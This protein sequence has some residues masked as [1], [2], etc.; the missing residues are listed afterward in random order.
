MKRFLVLTALLALL[1]CGER[2]VLPHPTALS[3][4]AAND[5]APQ[6]APDG[7]TL[8]WWRPDGNEWRLWRSPADLSAPESLPITSRFPGLL[9]WAP[10][11][12]RFAVGAIM[13]TSFQR[14]WVM[15][16]ARGSSPRRVTDSDLLEQPTG[17]NPDGRR[18]A[19][20]V[21]E[22]ETARG[23]AVDVDSGAPYRL[24]PT[25]S[26][27][28][29]AAWSPDGSQIL[30]WIIGEGRS[31]IWL[32]DSTGGGLR[33]LTTEG[34]E[35]PAG[36]GPA[37]TWSPDGKSLLYVSTRS[38]TGDLWLLP[39][40][41][42]A[43]RQL[44]NDVRDDNNAFWSPDGKWIAFTSDR[45]LQSDLWIVPAAGG[46][47]ER[48]T[49]DAAVEALTGWRPGTDQLVYT[50]GRT[51]NTTWAHTLADGTERQLTPDSANARWFNL[52]SDGRHV[53]V[54]YDR[55]GGVNDFA[56]V[57]VTGGEPRVILA[58]AGGGTTYGVAQ[59]RWSTHGPALVYVSNRGGSDDIWVVDTAGGAPRQL[60]DWPGRESDPR[61]SVD[62]QSILFV[63]D[64]DAK[65]GDVWRV[66]LAGGEPTRVTNGGLVLNMASQPT[67][68]APLF[69]NRV[70]GEGGAT[71]E[72]DRVREDGS[73]VTFWAGGGFG[74]VI[75]G[76]PP[77][78]TFG[79]RVIDAGGTVQAMLFPAG[80]G[81][82]RPLL[83]AGQNGVAFS[84]DGKQLLYEFREGDALDLAIL[85]L[86]DSSTRR[87]TTTP[88]S[89][90]ATEWSAD[91]TTLVF[92]RSVPISRITTA[93]LAKLLA[94]PPQQ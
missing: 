63:A 43:P 12:S 46:P 8:Y 36:S 14:L 91:G 16:T 47:A 1:A 65:W 87:I 74:F 49:D 37:G 77:P 69:V 22:G 86:A 18:L 55:G 7:A 25:E 90:D 5:V 53:V 71:V 66:P 82:G 35:F 72:M 20:I 61:W 13:G 33:P 52:S 19:D 45:G 31:T 68:S 39:V 15:D 44:T 89:E 17:W 6:Y 57:P 60:T 48:V 81:A 38:G 24:V 23:M 9:V 34:F 80:G 10:D 94:A 51:R 83:P 54:N 70:G 62:G 3:P 67:E 2:S 59:P 26:R 75:G 21:G 27:N 29:F 92:K 41:G 32:A 50:T 76:T 79:A 84:P 11:G 56:V 93:N 78:G 4:D 28:H 88:E 30:V 85:T 40:D 42:S 58:N 73:L 64:H